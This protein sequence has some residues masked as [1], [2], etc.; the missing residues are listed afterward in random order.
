ME[1]KELKTLLQQ[2]YTTDNWRKLLGHVFEYVQFL[3]TP[4]VIPTDDSRV[5]ELKQYGTVQLSD[6]KNLALFEL[7]L[8]EKVDLIRNRVGLNELVKK[9]I[10]Q[11]SY[12]GILSIFEQG[13]E[14]YRFTF[15]ARNTEFDADHGFIDKD[16][17]TKRF[18]YILGENES[19]RTAAERFDALSKTDN[20]DI[21]AV[22]DAFN[23]EKLSKKFFKEYIEQFNALV[24]YLRGKPTYYQAIFENDDTATR[25]FVKRFMGR[26]V[27]L[28]FIQKKGWLGVPVTE[29]G[30]NK[31][32]Y[33]FIEHQFKSFENKS[34]FVSQFL[35]PLFFEALNVGERKK[36]EFQNRGYKIPFL[37]GGLFDNDHPKENRIDFEEQ[38]LTN[39][40]DFFERYNFTIDENDLHDKEVGIDPEMLG[41]IFEN[42]LEDN[43]DKGAFYTPK[44]IVRYMCQE[45]LKEYL[46]TYLE[47]NKQWP[48]DDTA[49][50]TLKVNIAAFVEKKETAKILRFDKELAT[51]LRDVKICDPAIGSGAFPMGLLNEIFILIKNLHDESRIRL[52]SWGL[53]K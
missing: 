3:D 49:S 32:D 43:K 15:T 2:P 45:S 47:N 41:H 19:C 27:F 37:S 6:G 13:K 22:E 51:A 42:L 17:D 7:T 1:F 25:N 34:I 36:D 48:E 50:E 8:N 21:K 14:D 53:S 20:K 5:K 23:V 26:L 4:N 9:Y 10:D 30:W 38:A 24:G 33:Q 11:D 44:E 52:I 46:K 35:N 12:H 31:G 40:F 39:L 18:T 16:T 29:T 28:K